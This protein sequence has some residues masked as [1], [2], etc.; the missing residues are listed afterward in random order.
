M[1]GWRV[2]NEK[3]CA[4]RIGTGMGH[5]NEARLVVV[6][7]ADFRANI[8]IDIISLFGFDLADL[9]YKVWDN[10]MEGSAFVEPLFDQLKKIGDGTR[11]NI[12]K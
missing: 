7:L 1:R 6:E 3:M 8:V 5:T 2:S 11:S 10:P 12:R 9:G 4:F